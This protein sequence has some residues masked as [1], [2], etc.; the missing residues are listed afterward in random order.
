VKVVLERPDYFNYNP[1][2]GLHTP[3][4]IYPDA[5]AFAAQPVGYFPALPSTR[6]MLMSI[7]PS[8]PHIGQFDPSMAFAVMTA[9][10]P[11]RRLWDDEM[12]EVFPMW[13]PPQ[14]PVDPLKVW[15]EVRFRQAGYHPLYYRASTLRPWANEFV[16]GR[17]FHPILGW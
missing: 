16:P 4:Q 9:E 1:S 5:Y 6:P 11:K 8:P 7:P 13:S 12:R 14:R 15:P 2:D 17:L 10:Y 3:G